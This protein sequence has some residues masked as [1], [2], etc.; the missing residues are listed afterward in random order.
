MAAEAQAEGPA[1]P[2][3]PPPPLA[4]GSSSASPEKRGLLIPGNDGGGAEEERQLPEP[5]RRRACV[6]ALD[7]VPSSV[8]EEEA[9]DSPG[10]GCGGDGASFSFQHAR[11]GFVALE[12]TPKFGSF[13][14]PGEA[15]L[16][17]LDLKPPGHEA[18]A[19]GS[20]EADDKVEVPEASA[21]GA[22]VKDENS[23]LLGGEVDGQ[24]QA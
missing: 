17:G 16:A 23:Q 2:P 12:T 14:P 3:A 10:S 1:L 18:E 20:T 6:A 15:E 4:H 9:A 5:K 8:T 22:E 13:N 21:P 11:G 7:S 19:E 24:V